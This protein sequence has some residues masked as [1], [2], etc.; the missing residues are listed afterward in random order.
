MYLCVVA[1]LCDVLYMIPEIMVPDDTEFSVE[2]LGIRFGS[3]IAMLTICR[4]Y[5]KT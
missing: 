4:E 3:I 1:L 5:N 2:F